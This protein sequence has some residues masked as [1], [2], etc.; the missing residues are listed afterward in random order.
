MRKIIHIDADCFF[1]AVEMRDAPNLRN[2]PIAVGGSSDKRGVISTCNYPARKYGVRSAMATGYAMRL[3]PHLTLLPHRFNAYKEASVLM[4]EIFADY[5]DLIEPLSLDE[6]YL[7]VSGSEHCMGSATLIAEEIR[8]RIVKTIGITASAGVAENK[9]LAKVAS[10][11]RKPNGLTVVKPNDV[12]V[13]SANLPITCLSGVGKVTAEKLKALGLEKCSDIREMGLAP[14]VKRFGRFGASLYE[15]AHG[16]DSRPVTPSRE[17]KS[18]SIEHT[19]SKDLP[20]ETCEHQ[21]PDLLASL[22][23]RLQRA[24]SSGRVRKLFVKIK[25]SD[26]STTTMERGSHQLSFD[27]FRSLLLNAIKR[28]SLQ[29]R[30]LGVG[31]RLQAEGHGEQLELFE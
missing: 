1:A 2:K 9:F 7:D 14:L 25:F 23:S 15:C 20:R 11:W 28:S 30:L 5:T 31:V 19:Y 6:A 13:F 3:C 10:D 18:L 4:R 24:Q 29:V 8:A 22:S 16:R 12:D 26:F 17:R 27:V 21:L